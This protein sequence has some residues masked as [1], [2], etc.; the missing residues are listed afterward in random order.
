MD[1]IGSVLAGSCTDC[2]GP[3]AAD[4][5]AATCETGYNTFAD[6]FGCAN[7]GLALPIWLRLDIFY[8]V[9]TPATSQL[10]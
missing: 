1:G 2:D 6:G 4:C 3:N 9:I 7:D 10:C 8:I 5:T